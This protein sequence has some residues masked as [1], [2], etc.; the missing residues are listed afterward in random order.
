ME[1]AMVRGKWYWL[2]WVLGGLAMAMLVMSSAMKFMAPPEVVEG[3]KHLGW[4]M[5][6]LTT[7]GVIEMGVALLYLFPRT[8]VLGAI[9]VAGYLG[10][11]AATHMRLE[12]SPAMPVMLGVAAWAGLWLRDAR[13]RALIPWVS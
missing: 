12:E 2:G 3:M 11:A 5:T 9:L 10:G 6:M 8:A 1:T 4:P 13:V 7:L